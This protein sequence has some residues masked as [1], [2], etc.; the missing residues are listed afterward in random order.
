MIDTNLVLGGLALLGA[1]VFGVS[2]YVRA[3]KRKKEREA[4][5]KEFEASEA[6]KPPL[7]PEQIQAVKDQFKV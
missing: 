7:T 2:V 6:A 5:K 1:V 3:Q 4:S